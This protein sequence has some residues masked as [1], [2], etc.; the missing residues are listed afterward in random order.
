MKSLNFTLSLLS[1]GALLVGALHSQVKRS[2]A[3]AGSTVTQEFLRKAGPG[4]RVRL[5]ADN[6]RIESVVVL[7]MIFAASGLP[8]PANTR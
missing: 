7:T 4:W 5:S 8:S 6:R 1:L 3:V 2:N